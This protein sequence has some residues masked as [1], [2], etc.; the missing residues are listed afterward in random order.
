MRADTSGERAGFGLIGI[1]IVI[2]V[3]A[4]LGGGGWYVKEQVSRR[5]LLQTGLEAERKARELA[6]KITEQQ[7]Q[8]QQELGQP[9]PSAVVDTSSWKTYRNE[10]YGFEVKYPRGWTVRDSEEMI[11]FQENGSTATSISSGNLT[12]LGVTY[13]GAYP[14]DKRCELLGSSITIDWGT[15]G[16]NPSAF[17]QKTNEMGIFFELH[18]PR[19]SA[20]GIFREFLSTFKFIQ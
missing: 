20:G 8:L 3:I 14:D 9:T 7:S 5:S 18:L 15:T 1:I 16:N 6:E 12:V 13:C 11:L 17:I 4:L 2:A 10:K 19:D